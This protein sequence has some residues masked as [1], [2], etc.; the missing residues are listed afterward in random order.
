MF[1]LRNKKNYLYPCLSGSLDYPTVSKYFSSIFQAFY[2]LYQTFLC[3][4]NP[5]VRNVLFAYHNVMLIFSRSPCYLNT[6]NVCNTRNATCSHNVK[7][8]YLISLVIRR[9][10]FLPK[11]SQR[12]R[13][14]L[15]DGSRSLG[16]FR[17]G[18]IGIAKF[19][20]TDLII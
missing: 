11:Q 16:L 3:G 20:R 1:L 18:K 14:V 15:K 8:I 2:K 6:C 4:I 13:S 17:K 5:F 7:H 9:I 12:S 19:H 10:S